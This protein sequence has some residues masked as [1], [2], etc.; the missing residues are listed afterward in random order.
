MKLL[1]SLLACLYLVGCSEKEHTT[2][3]V[4]I[5]RTY[6]NGD[7]GFMYGDMDSETLSHYHI[8]ISK[9][10]FYTKAYYDSAV[11]SIT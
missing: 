2:N 10:T 1:L 3:Y 7:I 6:K 8:T 9:D 5:D 11:N 4:I